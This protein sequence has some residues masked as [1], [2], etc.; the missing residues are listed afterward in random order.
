MSCLTLSTQAAY[1]PPKIAHEPVLREN[2]TDSVALLLPIY[3]TSHCRYLASGLSVVH[4]R[5]KWL[6][7]G[8]PL[9]G[10][11]LLPPLVAAFIALA[12]VRG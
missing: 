11:L 1:P 2:A 6:L 5:S 3:Y 8:L 12:Y 10:G 9:F 4:Q 7:F